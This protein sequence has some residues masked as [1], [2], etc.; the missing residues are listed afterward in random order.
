ML[1][2]VTG[3]AGFIGS[4][5]I[6]QLNLRGYYDIIAV[7]NLTNGDKAKNLAD[8]DI[9]DFVD[10]EDFIQAIVN[11][12][13]DNQLDYIFH[14][15]ACSATVEANGRYIMKNNYEYSC[16]LLE[17]AQKNEVPLVYAS[18]AATYGAS[19]IFIEEREYEIPLN[20]YGYSKMLFDQTVRRYFDAGLRSPV[21]GLKYFNVYGHR[22]F[23][24][25]RMA[26]VVLHNF[27]QY[28]EHGQVKLFSGCQGYA[29]GEQLRDFI[30]VEDVVKVNL[31]FFD[32]HTQSPHEISGIFNCGTGKARSFNDLALATINACRQATG[33]TKLTLANAIEQG[34]LTYI[35]FPADLAGKYQCFTQSNNQRLIDL[36][37]YQQGF[38]SLEQG[39]EN[40]ISLLI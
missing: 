8:L 7:D 3:A 9:L 10:K 13:Y 28:Q 24:K 32:N 22:E 37:K 4:N 2:A 19:N 33:K 31:H 23:H 14:Q 35:P 20:A 39:I 30:S 27:R 21:V 5:L 34:I 11:G 18:S 26:S 40:Y 29:N 16:L 25:G 15:G 1:I 12:E 17:Y 6:R 36:G 38:L